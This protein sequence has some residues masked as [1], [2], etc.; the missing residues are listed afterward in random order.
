MTA[1]V[2]AISEKLIEAAYAVYGRPPE[3][4]GV[5]IAKVTQQQDVPAYFRKKA[6]L[7]REPRSRDLWHRLQNMALDDNGAA[8]FIIGGALKSL[9]HEAKLPAD[10]RRVIEELQDLWEWQETVRGEIDG[11]RIL[12]DCRIGPDIRHGPTL[13]TRSP[14][15]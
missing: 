4:G 15:S 11:S 6:A 10:Q 5:Y 7:A 3:K 2:D 12:K 14:T 13:L 8:E 1:P 9:A